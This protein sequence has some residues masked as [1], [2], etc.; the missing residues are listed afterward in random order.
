MRPGLPP[1]FI[2]STNLQPEEL[3][4]L[5]ESF[6]SVTWD[7]TEA[8]IVVGKITRRERALFELRKLKINTDEV[9]TSSK[10]PLAKRRKTADSDGRVE[11][12]NASHDGDE[13]RTAGS[14]L[15]KVVKLEWLTNSLKKGSALPFGD[16][17]LY[18]GRRKAQPQPLTDHPPSYSRAQHPHPGTSSS[19][20]PALLHETTSEHDIPLPPVPDFLHT[21]YSCQRPTPVD[22]P[23]ADFIEQLKEVRTLRLL[24]GD[25]VGVRAYST[26]IASLAAYP[27]AVQSSFGEHPTPLPLP[28]K[29]LTCRQRSLGCPA[30]ALRSLKSGSNGKRQVT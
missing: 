17:L 14:D 10:E 11:H 23:N 1:I 30:V 12:V 9:R 16:C 29:T 26:S 27:H 22:T 7:A 4:S 21:P 19:H 25:Q 8:E 3:H 2:L 5:E 13:A 6:D 18:Q 24:E 20:R 28:R 15:V